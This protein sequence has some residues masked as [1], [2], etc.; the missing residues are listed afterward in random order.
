MQ[1]DDMILVSVDDHVCEPPDMWDR[2]VPAI[3]IDHI[4]WECDSPHSDSTWPEAP[5][6]LWA[7]LGG[8]PDEDIHKITWRNAT[9]HFQY[10]PFAH[11]PKEQC[12]VG[13]LRE[14]AKHVDLAPRVGGGGKQPSDYARGYATIGDVMKQ[15]VH[16]LSTPFDSGAGDR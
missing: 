11:I 8:V 13:A 9:R 16:A 4:T 7:T 1:M 12:T 5:E 14:K 15:M 10:E 2:H 3:G 6:K